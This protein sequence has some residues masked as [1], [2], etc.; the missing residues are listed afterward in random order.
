MP[1]KDVSDLWLRNTLNRQ[2]KRK[3]EQRRRYMDKIA[4]QI[5][6]GSRRIT[7]GGGGDQHIK[8]LRIPRK[9]LLS[10]RKTF[11]KEEDRRGRHSKKRALEEKQ[12][13]QDAGIQSRNSEYYS[14]DYCQNCGNSADDCF[15]R[16]REYDVVCKHCGV[17]QACEIVYE[18]EIS[19]L[20]SVP[21]TNKKIT[22]ISERIRQFANCEPRIPSEDI[23]IIRRVYGAL[24]QMYYKTHLSLEKDRNSSGKET[25]AHVTDIHFLFGR[26]NKKREG[27]ST[28]R[29]ERTSGLSRAI[30]SKILGDGGP[31]F[32]TKSFIKELLSITDQREILDH[33][34]L[35]S[36]SS[37]SS[38]SNNYFSR[39]YA[40][41]WLQIK[42]YLCGG[43]EVYEELV[44]PLPNS[45]LLNRI[46]RMAHELVHFYEL[47]K[48][49]CKSPKKN[50]LSEDL[51]FLIILYSIGSDALLELYGW[52]FISPHMYYSSSSSLEKEKEKEK[53]EKEG[54]L[55]PLELDYQ[56][57][58]RL[59]DLLPSPS[60]EMYRLPP[61]G[62]KDFVRIASGNKKAFLM[63]FTIE[64]EEDENLS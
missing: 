16:T 63:G 25:T 21:T 2:D 3:E 40:E 55:S 32:I 8:S 58:S 49:E 22:Y 30:L 27:D 59:L 48:Q 42:I 46:Y 28:E 5:R 14:S 53:K 23:K 62:L 52:Y 7:T 24:C 33:G 60:K 41:R 43:K 18:N 4:N 6:G 35:F 47:K 34:K 26:R 13:L 19:T 31:T 11:K 1:R 10:N 17:V 44:V 51:L 15:I 39:R 38:S 56:C 37:S 29:R 50:M 9:N 45:E 12:I 61:G 36:S 20:S 54:S 64:E 57:Y